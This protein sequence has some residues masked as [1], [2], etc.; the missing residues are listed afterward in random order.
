MD[1][2]L[3]HYECTYEELMALEPTKHQDPKKPTAFWRSL[4]WALSVPAL[5]KVNFKLKMVEMDKLTKNE[6]ALILMNHSNFLDFEIAMHAL[7]PRKYNI[8]TTFD[9]FIG[10]ERA[11]RG[12]GCIPTRKFTTDFT[13]IKDIKY[14][15]NTLRTSVLMYPEA[16]YS[17]GGRCHIVPSSVAALIKRL[18]VPLVM[19]ETYGGFINDP[20]YNNLHNRKND[21]S[22]E[23]R[24][25][26][27][28]EQINEMS[29]E[30]IYDVI[31]KEFS[32]DGFRW[33]QENR[34]II[35]TVD[36]AQGLHK[37]LY[38]CPSCKCEG[39]T[40]GRGTRL[41]CR[42]CKKEWELDERGFMR[43]LDGKTEFEH[44]PDWYDWERECVREEIIGGTYG[45]D[46]SA[47]LYAVVNMK[48]VY[49][50][51]NGRVSHDMDGVRVIGY[52]GKLDFRKKSVSMYAVGAALYWDKIGDGI[53]VGDNSI[54]YIAA[55]E[56]NQHLVMKA[57]LASEEIYKILKNQ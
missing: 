37:I 53:S 50:L 28:P 31:K 22:A 45:F 9:A 19:L 47:R 51:G 6:P 57:R 10:K 18:G 2:K 56:T 1:F 39:Q 44:I 17:Y 30:E 35:D 33:Q 11:L 4:A 21:V 20:I 34:V 32:Y 25:V 15:L 8:I 5:L 29:I 27:S 55:P 43:A 14:C 36:R 3:E 40:E 16:D 54:T 46:V 42:A 7:W 48:G 23:L 12:V 38:K 52:D 24:Y 26:L 41:V 49:D 13:L